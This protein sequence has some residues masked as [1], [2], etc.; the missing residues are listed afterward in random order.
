MAS[1]KTLSAALNWPTGLP[2]SGSTALIAGGLEAEGSVLIPH[3]ISSTLDSQHPVILVSFRQT[4]NHY[5]HIMRKMGVNLTRHKFQFVNALLQADFSEL[6]Q[7]TRPH[8]TLAKWPAFF[9]WLNEQPP[10]MVIV[11]GLCALLDQGHTVNQVL[12][13][14]LSCQR[15]VETKAES[16]FAALAINVFLDEFSEVLVRSMIRRAHFMFNFT[17]LSSGASSD[18]AGQLTVIPGHLHFRIQDKLQ[19]FKPSALH[20]RVSDATVQFFSPGQSSV[21]L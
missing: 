9:E 3:F 19:E 4:F 18:V 21:V 15:I 7:P 12:Q 8:Y 5:M 14:M 17:G 20:Y 6:P 13:F 10:S 1:Y 2:A 11:D 16:S